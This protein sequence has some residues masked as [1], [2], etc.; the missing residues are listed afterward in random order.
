MQIVIV[1]GSEKLGPV[2][3]AIQKIIGG[4]S[5]TVECQMSQSDAFAP[6]QDSLESAAQKLSTGEVISVTVRPRSGPIRYVLLL[7]PFYDGASLSLYT[8]TVEYTAKSYATI[9]ESLLQTTGLKVACVGYEEGVELRDDCLRVE[10]FPWKQ[11]PLV[12]GA[13]RSDPSSESWIIREGPEIRWFRSLAEDPA[14]S[15]NKME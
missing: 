13:L 9:W 15:R 14:R 10:T 2:I 8:G 12:V 3:D 1:F 11:W 6:T 7:P 5:Y 4:V